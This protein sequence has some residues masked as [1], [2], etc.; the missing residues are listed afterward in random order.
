MYTGHEKTSH[1]NISIESNLNLVVISVYKNFHIFSRVNPLR[2]EHRI[3]NE[4]LSSVI[5][6]IYFWSMMC[7]GTIL[8]P[9][10]LNIRVPGSLL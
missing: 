1:E 7:M 10:A 6:I 3:R 5:D 9:P 8:S 4:N 2:S